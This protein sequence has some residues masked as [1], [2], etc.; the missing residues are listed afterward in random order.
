MAIEIEFLRG[1]PEEAQS[2]ILNEISC[3]SDKVPIQIDGNVYWI[4]SDVQGLIDNLT[5]Y[6][7]ELGGKVNN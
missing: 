7:E 3:G 6:V 2:R 5:D 4:H 1:L